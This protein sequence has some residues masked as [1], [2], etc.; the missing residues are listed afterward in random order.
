MTTATPVPE[1]WLRLRPGPGAA[2]RRAALA[3]LEEAA[4]DGGGRVLRDGEGDLLLALRDGEHG[5][6]RGPGALLEG[7]AA[8]LAGLFGE[9]ALLCPAPPPGA[10]PP[11]APAAPAVAAARFD[12]R[13]DPVVGLGGRAGPRLAGLHLHAGAGPVGARG[14]AWGT[15]ADAAEG[16]DHL[17][18]HAALGRAGEAAAALATPAG[19]AELLGA[20]PGVPL[21]LGWPAGRPWD[22]GGG[23]DGLPVLPVLPLS[24]LA[25]AAPPAPFALSLPGAPGALAALLPLLDPAALPGEA[26]HLRWEPLLPS[27]PADALDALGPGRMVLEGA[28]SEA[29]LAW[30]LSRGIGRFT[31]AHPSRLLAA[32]RRRDCASGAGCTPAQCA[33][34]AAAATAAGRA[35][36]AEPARLLGGAA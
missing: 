19:R 7:V 2:R 35:G 11:P 5:P 32:L 12:L 16:D 13:R 31:G 17:A 28:D 9:S 25:S 30:G 24:A 15:G 3:L 22:G 1:R 33:A 36:C 14:E 6:E 8:R 23:F 4:R 26:L 34:R 10:V 18:R 29:A 21:H 27:L 20:P